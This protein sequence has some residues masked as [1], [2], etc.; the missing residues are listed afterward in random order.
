MILIG[1]LLDMD[2]YPWQ[3]DWYA[4]RV[5]AEYGNEFSEKFR[6]WFNDNA[7]HHDGSV[8]VSGRH[9]NHNVRLV[10]YVGILQQALRDVSAWVERGADPAASTDYRVVDGQVVLNADS[11]RRNGIQ[12]AVNLTVS[13]QKSEVL[14]SGDSVTLKAV[15]D[16]P[17][18]AGTIT[19]IEWNPTGTSRD[20]RPASF[21]PAGKRLEVTSPRFTYGT[22]RVYFPVIRITLHRE[23]DNNSGAA[24]VQNID[25]VRLTVR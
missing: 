8:I 7:D 14:S 2:A 25:R 20:F 5:R 1:N 6:I 12:P 24:G 4:Q 13:G 16:V 15:I 18:G 22:R 21:V 10:S 17:A 23:G 19:S 3:G 11:T 9:D